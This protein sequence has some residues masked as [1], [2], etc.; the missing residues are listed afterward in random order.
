M[1]YRY[2]LKSFIKCKHHHN[3]SQ[4]TDFFPLKLVLS[5]LEFHINRT[6]QHAILGLASFL[7]SFPKQVSYPHSH[8][9]T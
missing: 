6:M 2:N 8:L 4:T 5:S 3:P 9:N 7:T 1:E